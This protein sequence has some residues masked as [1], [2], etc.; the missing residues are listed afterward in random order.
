MVDFARDLSELEVQIISSGGTANALREADISVTDIS[1]I[2]GFPEMMDGRVKTLHPKVH[3]G[4]LALRDNPDHMNQAQENDIGLIDLVAVNLYPFQETVAREDATLSEA[5]E[6]IDIGGPSL[7]RAAAKNYQHVTVIVDP[8]DY[9]QVI[10][11]IKES[12]EA[13]S[14]LREK[15]AVK[16]FR[17]TADYDSAIDNYLSRTLLD[18]QILRLSFIHGQE[19]RHGENWHQ[20]A[21]FYVQPGATEGT[22]ASAVQLHG[23]QMSYNNYVDADS[24]LQVVKEVKGENVVA[25]V[26]HNNPC[27]LAA[28]S[29][30]LDALG[31]A[32]DGD[33]ISAFGSII[34]TNTTVDTD[35]AEFLQGKF[36]ELILA[37]DYEEVALEQLKNKSKNLRLL[38]LTDLDKPA[39][40]DYVYRH[41]V[42]GM[43][44]QTPN[45]GLFEKWDVVTEHQFPDSKKALAEFACIACKHIK[46]NDVAIAQEY[47]PGSYKM[48][49]MGAG[50]PNRV[51]AIRKLAVTKARENLKL[52]YERERPSASEEEY[53]RSVLSECV[54]V[55]DAFFPFD[56]SI[57]HAAEDHIMYIVSPGGS[58]RDQ[59]VI[60]TANRLGVSLVFTGMRHF[61]H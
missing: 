36:V 26:K 15:L 30:P 2:T 44:E 23:K 27:G 19:L 50:Q 12:G 51:D 7:V 55:S 34:C 6:N 40:P 56:D 45:R 20:T 61:L 31:A 58:I 17:H 41:V 53:I 33:P 1:D 47:A 35:F 11:E 42:G 54:M 39:H 21:R 4:I 57:I 29:T 28:G 10:D 14:Q 48:L 16:A 5:I 32:W 38:K 22:V 49:S 37:P 18:E 8:A 25:V 52:I 13:S 43:L 24:A 59:E 3:G 9:N 60:D 46:S